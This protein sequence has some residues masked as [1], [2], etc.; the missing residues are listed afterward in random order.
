[1]CGLRNFKDVQPHPDTT[2]RGTRPSAN[3]HTCNIKDTDMPTALQ[4]TGLALASLIVASGMGFAENR[5]DRQLPGAPEMAAYG[6]FAV[7]VRS[8]TIVNPDQVDIQNID[9]AAPKPDP[10]PRYDRPLT[11]EVW[12]PAGAGAT[13][14]T[15]LMADLRD[16]KTVVELQGKAMRDAVPA[17]DTFPLVIISHGYPGNRF[18]L[19]HLA[20]N[21]A[22]KG[23]V[24]ASIDHTDSVY[25]NL[26]S[27]GSTL[28][29]RPLDQLFTLSEMDRMS[30]DKDSFLNGLVDASNTA[31]IGYS[32]GG[33]GAVITMGAGV[34][35]TSID[36]TWGAPHG[37]LA[38]HKAGSD[39][40][41]ALSDPRIK[42]AIAFAPWGMNRDF[43]DA[44]S[45]KGITAP[46]L[47]IAGSQD[48]VS[49]YENGTR[50]IWQGAVNANRSLLT[51]ENANHNAGAPMPAPAESYV[52]D[53]DL[54]FDLSEH[55]TDAV[56]DTVRMNNIAQ[57]FVTVWLGKYLKADAAMDGYLDLVPNSNDGVWA[58]ADD[59]KDLP[60]NT[61]WK[62]FPDRTAKGLRFEVLKPAQ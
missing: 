49:G 30:R 9:G 28:V 16:G 37:T 57:H 51:Y 7:G 8:V 34:T 22:S 46:M 43:W 11:L 58:K 59:G 26:G 44:E 4:T 29:N 15:A 12:Y 55:Y 48:D 36:Y 47:F 54:G 5:I 10:L 31:L 21:I 24:V 50:A 20:E 1:M 25:R 62:G 45:L 33:Y 35:Q 18:L 39:S 27:F 23:Y 42:T 52:F 17:A 61:Y 3:R 56:W 19:S 2:L 53:A 6:A 38:I 60:E 13:G 32:M 14:D 40:H 41:K